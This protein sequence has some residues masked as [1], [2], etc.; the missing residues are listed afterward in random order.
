MTAKLESFVPAAPPQAAPEVTPAA[1]PNTVAKREAAK[2]AHDALITRWKAITEAGGADEWV[3]AQLVA[4]GALADEVDF[5]SLKEKEKTAWKE[6]KKAEAVERR[7]LERQAH[8][9]WKATHVNHLGV[10][11]HWNEAGLPDKFDLEHREERARQN[12]LPTLNNAEDLAKALGLSVS[13]LRGFAFHRDVDTGSHYVTWSIPKRTGGERTITSPKPELKQAQ[14][15]V[16]SNVVERLPVH[17][18]AHGF[19]AG[20]SILTNAL[21][22]QGA[23]VLVKVDLKD[24]FPSVNWRRVKGLLR[25]G[26]LPENT[27]TLLALMSTEAPRERMSFR[28]KTL[29]VA[30]GPRALPQGAPT[31]PGI[32]NALCLRL[33]KRLSALSR[34]L[35][36]TYT[37][38]A[39]DLTFSWTKAKAPKARRAQGAPVAVLLARV[40]DVVEA[41]GFTV[42]PDKTRVA[43]RGSRQR[44]TGLVI[45]EAKEGTPAAR[46]P[47]DVVRRLR[48]AIHNRLQGKPGREGE[49]LEQLKGMAAFIH[50]TDP[51]KGRMYLDQLAKLEAAQA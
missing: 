39:D 49:S 46:V 17:G 18:A 11:I 33:D 26:G 20:R 28:G 42:H 38:Y 29:H 1:S 22:H 23:D 41:E 37:R 25:K 15:W 16:L 2:A 3:H 4:K 35:G 7:A 44:V 13:K 50:M 45:N 30:K 5:S 51:E 10:G 14:R 19:V 27:S 8:E 43:R 32:T 6:K 34:K 40:K 36:F 47:R 21:A 24:F 12:G 31:S 48:A 9:A